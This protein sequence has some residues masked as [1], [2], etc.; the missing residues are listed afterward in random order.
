MRSL[1]YTKDEKHPR[2]VFEITCDLELLTACVRDGEVGPEDILRA[3]R[4]T[5]EAVNDAALKGQAKAKQEAED[6]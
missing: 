2:I 3:V 5:M 4:R 6:V 1:V